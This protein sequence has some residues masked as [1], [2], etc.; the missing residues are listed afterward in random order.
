[1]STDA[2]SC[3]EFA[4]VVQDLVQGHHHLSHTH[5][6]DGPRGC[7]VFVRNGTTEVE[8]RWDYRI[9]VR[10]GRIVDGRVPPDPIHPGRGVHLNSHYLDLLLTL[11]APHL[12]LGAYER[13]ES[14]LEVRDSVTAVVRDLVDAMSAYAS[15][16]LAGDF[17][18][19]EELD[20]IAA[21]QRR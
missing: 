1:V 9:S 14:E 17:S 20:E 5:T 18:V 11:R 8:F 3:D 10:L 2:K 13:S 12:D 15:D 4:R 6:I 7:R 16:V 21:E 19:F